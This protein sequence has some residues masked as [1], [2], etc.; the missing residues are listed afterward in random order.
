M[1]KMI[2]LAMSGARQTLLEQSTN[3]H[4][5]ANVNT[6]GFRAQMDAFS[7]MPVYG[8]GHPDRVYAQTNQVGSS[9]EQ[10]NI[11]E[12]GNPLD[13]AIK[14]NGF[15]AVQDVD[16][17]EAYTRAGDL[18]INAEGLLQTSNGNLVLG[19]GGPISLSPYDEISVA[20]DGTI[21]IRPLGQSQAELAVLDRIKLVNP[22]TQALKRNER[23][24]FV[25]D[26]GIEAADGNVRVESGAIESSNVN[27]VEALVTMIELSR[28]FETQVKMMSVAEEN[29]TT[30]SRL[31]QS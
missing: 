26:N 4:N 6:T 28:Q 27:S 3:N 7:A 21:T 2:Y 13:I 5:L 8:P 9:Y 11:I 16:G 31:L 12:T 14:G 23:G 30:A 19:N 25:S 24:L 15:I 18:K 29:D 17:A 1:D 20:N 10:G 22:E